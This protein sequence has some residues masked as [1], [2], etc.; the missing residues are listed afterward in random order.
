MIMFFTSHCKTPGDGEV[1]IDYSDI[2]DMH[3]VL[4]QLCL[5]FLVCTTVF[6]SL[7]FYLQVR[8]LAYVQGNST[9]NDNLVVL[10]KL[11]AARHEIAQVL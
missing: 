5:W 3:L 2:I 6:R 1:S 11:I 9:P 7:T 10:D 4:Q 8:K